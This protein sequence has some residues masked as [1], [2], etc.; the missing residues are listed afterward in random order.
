[1]AQI[2]FAA[3]QKT[4]KKVVKVDEKHS[5]FFGAKGVEEGDEGDAVVVMHGGDGGGGTQHAVRRKTAMPN[6][7]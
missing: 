4:P 2:L 5:V 3:I 1:V 6:R 7:P